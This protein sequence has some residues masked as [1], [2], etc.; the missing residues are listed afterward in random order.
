MN[1]KREPVKVAAGV[2]IRRDSALGDRFFLTKRHAGQHQGNKWEFP[3]GKVESGETPKQ[4]LVREL[5]EE[6]GIRVTNAELLTE[7][8][9]DYGD[10]AVHLLFYVVDAFDGEP[11]GKEGQQSAWVNRAQLNDIDFPEANKAVLKLL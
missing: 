5:F 7:I 10:K 4:S 3:G 1:H 9:H 6:I 11:I 2:I 8:H